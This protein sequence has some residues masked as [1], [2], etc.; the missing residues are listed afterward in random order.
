MHTHVLNVLPVLPQGV[1]LHLHHE[2][3]RN[4]VD[5]LPVEHGQGVRLPGVLGRAG[6]YE[7]GAVLQ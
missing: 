7:E 2:A 1:A 6:A 5:L 4:V 3:Y